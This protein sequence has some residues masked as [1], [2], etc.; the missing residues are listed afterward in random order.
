[1]YQEINVFDYAATLLDQIDSGIFLSTQHQ[2]RKNTMTIGWGGITVVWGKPIFMALVRDCRATY[3]L[4]EKQNAFTISVP[5][6]ADLK[7]ALAYCGR[8][9]LRDGDKFNHCKL[10]P[11]Q[12][13]KVPAPIV[14][15][16]ELHYECQVIYK[17]T[18][19]ES[20]IPAHIKQRYYTQ[21][22]ANHTMYFGEIVD[23][24]LYHKDPS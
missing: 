16:A 4:L 5:I 23:Q 21:T 17:Q 3:E 6:Q 8:H 13:R 12:G 20:Q 18:L 15:E 9:S 19:I 7:Q 2:N 10:T 24:Y 14:G 22:T 1:M 11:V